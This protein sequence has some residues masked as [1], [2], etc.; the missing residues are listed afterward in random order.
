MIEQKAWKAA[1]EVIA[2]LEENGYEA[3]IVGG[4]V[5]DSLRG[6]TA[7]DVDVATNAVPEEVKT[8]FSRTADVGISHGTVLV[9]HPL[10]PVEVTTYRTEGTYQDHRRPDEVYFVSSLAEDL[11]RRDFTINAMAMSGKQ[12]IIDLFGGKEDLQNGV[13][14]AVGQPL[15]RFKEDA[16]RMLRAIRFSAQLGFRIEESTFK[17]ISKQAQ[18]IHFIAKERIKAE[19]DKIFVS[20]HPIKAMQNIQQSGLAEFLP[21]DYDQIDRWKKFKACTDAWKGWAYFCL[22]Q[23][24]QDIEIMRAF[25][26]SNNE[27][28]QV[29]D[30][31]DAHQLLI[32]NGWTKKQYFEFDLVVLKTA[33]EFANNLGKNPVQPESMENIEQIKMNLAIQKK[34]DLAVSGHDLI[35]W[36]GQKSGPWL[37]ESLE[38]ILTEILENRL[39]NDQ[40]QIKEWFLSERTY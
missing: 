6:H 5:R 18:D 22:L 32:S 1:F 13:I 21:G 33:H 29:Q 10:S 12:E 4:A 20:E 30:I 16:L 8:V 28:K 23:P 26:C 9:I 34:T 7:N 19:F 40:Q 25:K 17:A 14:R 3:F 31:I 38:K 2:S 27:K 39:L 35:K 37:K 15:E 11:K 36:S 24:N